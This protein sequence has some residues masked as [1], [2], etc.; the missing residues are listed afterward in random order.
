MR[1]RSPI[2]VV[3]A[4]LPALTAR[5]I[6]QALHKLA[7]G[8]SSFVPDSSGVGTTLLA[9]AEPSLRRP[10]YGP[11]SARLHAAQGAQMVVYVDPRVRRDVDTV[12]DLQEAEALGVGPRTASLVEGLLA[13]SSGARAP[14]GHGGGVGRIAVSQC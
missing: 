1:P 13:S 11:G 3:P 2:V 4:D 10:A 7:H 9:A 14:V 8:R 6:D 5:T 12:R